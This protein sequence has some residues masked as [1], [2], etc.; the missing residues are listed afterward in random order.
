TQA[1]LWC[2]TRRFI[3]FIELR[4]GSFIAGFQPLLHDDMAGGAGANSPAGMVQPHLEALGNIQDAAGQPVVAVGKL[5]R[6][7]LDGFAARK[8]GH[9]ELFGRLL[10]FYFLDVRIAAAH[11]ALP[12]QIPE[13]HLKSFLQGLK[14]VRPGASTPGLKPRPPEE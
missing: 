6:I 7:D 14:P 4:I 11:S 13:K 3:E 8:K 2:D 12:S 10:V 1:R 5:L 9:L